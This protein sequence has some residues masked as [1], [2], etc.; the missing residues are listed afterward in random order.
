MSAAGLECR[1]L[2]LAR[3]DA[4]GSERR[5]LDAIDATFAPG[6][7][8]LVRGSTGAGKS[9][10]LHLLA[11]LLRPTSGEVWAAGE[12]VSRYL[13]SHRDRWRR[14]VGLVFQVSQLWPDLSAAENVMLPLVPSGGSLSDIRRR[15]SE[16]LEQ[17]GALA[18]AE[19]V[20]TELS[21]GE[22]QRVALARA[23]VVEPVFLLADEPT[24]HQDPEGIDLVMAGLDRARDRGATVVVASHDPRLLDGCFAQRQWRLEAGQ[25]GLHTE[26]CS[27]PSDPGQRAG[28][29]GHRIDSQERGD[30]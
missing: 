19:R 26:T 6:D 14:Q 17:V 16:A 8:S 21:V 25:L 11:G 18:L 7:L 10:L 2:T 22:Q 28:R 20:A 29:D 12:P 23:L 30:D 1:E 9:S 13:G 3:R 5:V 24:A 27:G 15:V 4:R